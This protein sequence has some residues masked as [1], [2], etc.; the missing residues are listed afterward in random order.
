[1]Q[2]ALIKNKEYFNN[3]ESSDISVNQ[4]LK[5]IPKTRYYGSKKR[6]LYWIY[7]LVKEI[8]FNN[9][10]DG[11]GGTCSASLL[12]KAMDKKVFYCDAL[13]SNTISAKAILCNN[14]PFQDI[15]YGYDFISKIN[16]VDGF[17]AKTFKDKYFTDYEN[18]WIDG[19]IKNINE[20]TSDDE[21]NIFLYCLFQS[22]LMKRPFNLFHR[23]NLN[24]RTN[25][26]IVRKFGNLTTW[27]REFSELMIQNLRSIFE[28]KWRSRHE[29]T[30]YNSSDIFDI[31]PGY[32]L[33]YLDPPYVDMSGKCEDYLRRYHFLEGLS[34][35]STWEKKIN[36]NTN[37]LRFYDNEKIRDWNDKTKNKD[38]LYNLVD[39]HKKSII[40]LSYI[41]DANPCQEDILKFF[42]SKFKYVQLSSHKLS[43]AL[44]ANKKVEIVVIGVP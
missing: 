43:H 15:N 8:S 38:M 26:N 42:K 35:V 2:K 31:S 24:L 19:A 16:P 25:E 40:A 3:V 29:P 32:D 1:M 11:F 9:V 4:R 14:N 18:S 12:F 37:N 41:S 6:I 22:C 27:N 10:L 13:E 30:I 28:T 21:K 20:L 44:S 39:K 17:V 23:A 36:K 7:D 34:D 5:S 33:V